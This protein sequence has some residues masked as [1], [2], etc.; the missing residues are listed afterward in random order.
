MQVWGTTAIQ[1][2]TMPIVL[3]ALLLT[4]EMNLESSL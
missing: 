3:N 1:A 4:G 2:I